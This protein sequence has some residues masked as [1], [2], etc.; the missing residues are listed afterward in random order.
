MRVVYVVCSLQD[1]CKYKVKWRESPDAP[2][3]A[4]E[5]EDASTALG[6]PQHINL[7]TIVCAK[8]D[9][10]AA[11][12]NMGHTSIAPAVYGPG[13]MLSLLRGAS[14]LLLLAR[15]H[16]CGLRSFSCSVVH[17]LHVH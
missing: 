11:T 15:A 1:A 5:G 14:V 13:E 6:G 9:Y 17:A 4:P 12:G 3:S 10:L 7:D 8:N 16:C 2:G